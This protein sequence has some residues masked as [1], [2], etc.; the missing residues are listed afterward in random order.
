MSGRRVLA[1]VAHP[2]DEAL[3]CGGTLA[4]LAREGS[5]V[6]VLLPLRRC[7]HRGVA[8]WEELL[9]AFARS[10]TTL[11][12]QPWPIERLLA[13]T[14]AETHVHELHDAIVPA[15]E[16]ADLVLTHWS[17]DANQVHRGVARAVEIA[18]RPFRRHKEVCLFEVATSTDQA[19]PTGPAFAPDTYV[20]LG[21][22]DA[23]RKRDA[24]A[25]YITEHAPGRTA[26]DVERKLRVRGAEAG[27]ELAE[28][29]VTVR[30]FV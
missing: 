18:T 28:A 1:V 3:G 13:E 29:L 12:A 11:G 16:W 19:F 10:C 24:I 6:R 14:R 30:R 25:A 2:D 22:D 21:A 15:V 23:R 8:H 7:D 26:E 20:V 27:V 5:D 17:G 4:K 9:H